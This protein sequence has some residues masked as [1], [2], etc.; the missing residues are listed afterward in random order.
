MA[1]IKNTF[2]LGRMNKD[3]DERLVPNGEYRDALNVNITNSEGSDVGAVENLLGNE[4]ISAIAN[5]LENPKTIGSIKWDLQEKIYWFVTSDYS[6]AIYEYNQTQNK[7]EPVLVDLKS[8]N[9]AT[10]GGVTIK[11]NENSE[12]IIKNYYRKELELI[13]G[14]DLNLGLVGSQ[15]LIKNTVYLKNTVY[16]IDIEIHKNTII[17]YKKNNELVF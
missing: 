4:K 12:L 5:T 9:N 3:L 11:S 1:E 17:E 15:T 7:V 2:T 16:N 8:K 10:L 14:N 6:D 13:I